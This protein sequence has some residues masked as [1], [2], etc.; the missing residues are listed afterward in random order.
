MAERSY[1]LDLFSLKTWQEF[2]AAGSEV[3]G[4]RESR[5]STVQRISVGDYLLCY[6]TG[7]S[8]FVAVLEVTSSPH[9]DRSTIWSDE[10]FPC[11]LGVKVV[12]SLSAETAVPIME[13]R[14]T[15][16]IFSDLSGPHA[17]TGRVRGSPS[18]WSTEDGE[19]ILAALYEAEQH[20]VVRPV[21]ARAVSRPRPVASDIGAVTVPEGHDTAEADREPSVHEQVQGLLLRLGNDM[22]LDVWSARND[23]SKHVGHGLRR[24]RA[25]LPRQFD[26]AT[27]R[28]IELIDVLWL[29]GNTIVAAFEIEATTS[30]YSGLLRMSDLVAMQPN[31]KIPLYLV[32]PEERREKVISEVNRPTFSRLS[33]PLS[34]I[35]RYMAFGELQSWVDRVQLVVRHLSPEFLNDFSESL[36]VEEV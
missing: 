22:G 27:N 14:E 2:W 3:S 5:W 11:R 13:L 36:E 25:E 4:F 17:W 12:V 21:P 18:R 24:L 30:I 16:S 15:L 19:A 9:I 10:I 28:T 26:E 29:R 8:R 20:P 33:P 23:R 31:L 35:C 34:H 7:L 1:W 6:L 32:A